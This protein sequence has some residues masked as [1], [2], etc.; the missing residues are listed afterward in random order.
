MTP[1]V[2]SAWPSYVGGSE[3]TTKISSP[4]ERGLSCAAAGPSPAVTANTIAASTRVRRR[5]QIPLLYE[6]GRSDRRAR[7]RSAIPTAPF[8]SGEHREVFGLLGDELQ[9][10]R[11]ALARLGDRAADGGDDVVRLGDPLAVAA[12]RL[13][14]VGVV[15]ADV[16]RAVL[17]R[18]GLHD[19]QLD[20]HREV[21]REHGQ[22]RDALAHRRLEVH[23]GEA[24]GGVTPEVDAELLGLGLAMGA[25]LAQPE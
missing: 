11:H 8:G 9:Q 4:P 23:A 18:G 16:G 1:K 21:V 20:G 17:L 12:Q 13:G 10:R 3:G 15:A 7:G 24:D 5:M 14:E 25:K 22:D 6:S 19:L 2:P